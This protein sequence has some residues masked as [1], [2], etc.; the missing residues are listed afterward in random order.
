M[1][2]ME[3]PEIKWRVRNSP[4][5]SANQLADYMTSS[6]RRRETIVRDAKYQSV[7]VVSYY[8]AADVAISRFLSDPIRNWRVIH[9]AMAD[10]QKKAEAPDVKP[11]TRERL[12]NNMEALAAF[13]RNYN[14]L[15]LTGLRL[16]PIHG[17]QPKTPL[18]G[19]KLSIALDFIVAGPLNEALVGGLLFELSKGQSPKTAPAK[20]RLAAFAQHAATLVHMH[21]SQHLNSFGAPSLKLCLW[22][23]VQRGVTQSAPRDY[24]GLM[25]NMAAACRV[26]ARSWDDADPPPGFDPRHARFVP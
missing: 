26:I 22:V 3:T 25:D 20:A 5:M 6:E 23:D 1:S 7:V 21:V 11:G 9:Q 24:R 17:A 8:R 18:E 12:L 16:T 13:E 19:V 15:G 14:S 4:Q 2:F 10:L